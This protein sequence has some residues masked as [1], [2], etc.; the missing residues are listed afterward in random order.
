MY[1][2]MGNKRYEDYAETIVESGSHLLSM[3]NDVLDLSKAEVGELELSE[4]IVD[5]QDLMEQA[6][7]MLD[8]QAVAGGIALSSHVSPSC[9]YLHGDLAS[10]SA[11]RA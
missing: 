4:E 10:D 2:P 6:V 8:P 11:D 7:R 5:L 1:G 3:V 9:P